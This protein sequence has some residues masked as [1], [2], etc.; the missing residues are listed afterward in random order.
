MYTMY[1]TMIV[2]ARKLITRKFINLNQSCIKIILLLKLKI[3]IGLQNEGYTSIWQ[4]SPLE[5]GS[6]S[7]S[8]G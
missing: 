6:Q 8:R 1:H 3:I 2:L 4:R 7:L 5:K